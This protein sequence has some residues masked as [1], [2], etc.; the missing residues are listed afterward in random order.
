MV[1]CLRFERQEKAV[2]NAGTF[3]AAW[4]T[5]IGCQLNPMGAQSDTHEADIVGSTNLPTLV[6][7]TL[8][9]ATLILEM[10]VVCIGS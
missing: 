8:D 6:I 10:Y 1:R 3:V 9:G 5:E 2:M 7:R 4:K